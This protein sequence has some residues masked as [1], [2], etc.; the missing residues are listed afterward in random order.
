MSNVSSRGA[1]KPTRPASGKPFLLGIALCAANGT[2][3][4]ERCCHTSDSNMRHTTLA[5]LIVCVSAAGAY[6]EERWVLVARHG[7]CIP[8]DWLEKDDPELVGTV[9]TPYQYADIMRQRGYQVDLTV[10]RGSNGRLIEV[11]VPAKEYGLVF[12]LHEDCAA[13]GSLLK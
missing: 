4:G 12:T 2:R 1:G 7:E 11:R 5:A 3:T 10:V 6:A 13:R 9:R 8:V